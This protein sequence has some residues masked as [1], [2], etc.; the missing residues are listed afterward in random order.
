MT[1]C[2]LAGTIFSLCLATTAANAQIE[3]VSYTYNDHPLAIASSSANI[4]TV[5]QVAVPAGLTVSSVTVQVNIQYPNVGDLN[6]YLFSAQGTRTVLLSN[7]CSGLADVNTTFDDTAPT[8]FSS[9]CPAEAGR[10]PF[11]GEEPLANSKGEFSGGYWQL[12][13]QSTKNSGNTGLLMGFEVNITGTPVT[14]PGF[15]AASVVNGASGVADGVVA[16]GELVT[17]FG[18]ALGP[19][20][21]VGA[22]TQV[23]P[24]SLGGTTVT[25][26]NTPAPILYSS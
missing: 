14:Q 17:I 20:Q 25:F 10:G 7:D 4:S 12:V 23:L 3:T 19:K 11:R 9:F 16:P 8:K 24:T 1:N 15:T 18:V 26:D 5:A 22:N 21:G 13:I 2:K 6:V